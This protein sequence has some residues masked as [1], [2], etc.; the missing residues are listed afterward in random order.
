MT[1]RLDT[2]SD[3]SQAIAGRFADLEGV[4]QRGE[5]LKRRRQRVYSV[6]AVGCVAGGLA[7]LRLAG[8]PTTVSFDAAI[9]SDEAPN[10]LGPLGTSSQAAPPSTNQPSGE[11][12]VELRSSIEPSGLPL[13]EWLNPPPTT[14]PVR[15]QLTILNPSA[16]SGC[17][18]LSSD[19]GMSL[20]VWPPGSSAIFTAGHVYNRD[21][22]VIAREGESLTAHVQV[23]PLAEAFAEE[24]GLG[25]CSP[26]PELT[27][28]MYVASVERTRAPNHGDVAVTLWNGHATAA[29]PRVP[30]T[31]TDSAGRVI[32]ASVGVPSPVTLEIPEGRYAVAVDGGSAC[33][34]SEVD[35]QR[36]VDVVL[37]LVWPEQAECARTGSN[38]PPMLPS[39]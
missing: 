20:L 38:S 4:M 15:G 37:A 10:V 17:V 22:E 1:D 11:R 9:A 8:G 32:S 14:V 39:Q 36:N 13:P 35:V 34:A 23:G 25:R 6:L 33:Y 27:N 18:A 16:D 30:F 26:P 19:E 2:L 21:G 7:G 5:R 29:A 28:T 12:D 3:A 31:L 24:V